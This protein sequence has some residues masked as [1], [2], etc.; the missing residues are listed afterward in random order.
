MLTQEIGEYAYSDFKGFNQISYNCV[1]YLLN[2]NELVWKLLKYN[3]PDAWNKPDLTHEEKAELI[4]AGQQDS[5]KFKVFL[6]SKQP[7]VL[8]DETTLLRIMPYFAIGYNR[9][10]SMMEVSMEVYSHYK[11]NHLSNYTT[12]VDTIAGELLTLFNGSNMGTL[13][14]LAIDKMVD[15]SSRLFSVGQ[16][17]FGGKQVLF[18]T[19]TA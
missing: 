13:G 15:Q 7:D 19:Y 4:Y 12:R 14:Y 1:K 10:L 5:S 6:D 2:N 18:S 3:G 11:I 9:T 8:M 16:I 17:P